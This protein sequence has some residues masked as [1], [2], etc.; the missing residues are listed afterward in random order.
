MTLHDNK[1][2]FRQAI[3]A[4]AQ[5]M[6]NMKE[7]YVEKDY[8]VTLALKTIYESKIGAEAIFKGGTSLSKC[9]NFI[10]RFSE[11]IDIVAV[12][13]EGESD[14]A[15]NAKVKKISKAIESVLPEVHIDG[16]TSKHGMLRKTAH[17]Y[18]KEFTGVYGQVRDV[19]VLEASSLGYFEPHTTK[20]I[21][22][23]ISTMMQNT[24]RAALITQYQ[25]QAFDVLVLAPERTFCEKI[26]SLVRFSHSANAINDLQKKVRHCY[27]LHFLLQDD[28]INAFFAS[29]SFDAMMLKVANDDVLSYKN[30]NEWLAIHPKEA[31]IF[32]DTIN[33]WQQL[34]NEYVNEFSNL[35]YGTLP[36]ENEIEKTL[37]KIADRIKT[38]NWNINP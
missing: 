32:A 16:V 35:V 21:F 2:L 27:D 29:N 9:Y 22:S 23:F 18:A 11:D 7:I 13:K 31:I 17:N 30:G 28:F 14:S 10:E 4:T 6:Q 37:F 15:V 1:T 8:W 36:T 20:T 24:G 38:I 33:V 12:R 19:V 5:S 34:K 25:M 3:T 26:M